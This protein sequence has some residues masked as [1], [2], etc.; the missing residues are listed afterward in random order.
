VGEIFLGVPSV[1]T[2]EIQTQVLVEN[3]ETIVLGGV[4]ETETIKSVAKTPFLGD[5]PYL[6]GFFK[7]TI[8]ADEK[9]ELLVFITPTLIE[10][11]AHNK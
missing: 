4:Y 2:R 10:T 3:G 8:H 6:G 11:F 7:R 1:D 9:T 5:I